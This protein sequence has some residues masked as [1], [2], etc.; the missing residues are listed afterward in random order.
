MGI[1][2]TIVEALTPAPEYTPQESKPNSWTD[3]GVVARSL[4]S[5]SI[6]SMTAQPIS[7]ACAMGSAHTT[8]LGVLR[9]P[10]EPPVSEEHLQERRQ[11][12]GEY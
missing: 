5:L 2:S 3:S 7:A 4:G 9:Y 6:L 10:D 11:A 12:E 1:L 8:R